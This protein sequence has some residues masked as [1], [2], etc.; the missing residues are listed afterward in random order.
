MLASKDR[1]F[2]VAEILKHRVSQTRNPGS[3]SMQ[4]RNRTYLGRFGAPGEMLV[5]NIKQPQSS[6]ASSFGIIGIMIMMA[7]IVAIIINIVCHYCHSGC[8]W[9]TK[10]Q[11]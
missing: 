10:T 6:A 5:I 11:N 4:I 3:A 7:H 2:F 1:H 9:Y 8:Y